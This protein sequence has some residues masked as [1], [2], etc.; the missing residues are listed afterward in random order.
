ME[1]AAFAGFI[2][3]F[4]TSNTKA[5]RSRVNLV[6][7]IGERTLG[8]DYGLRRVGLAVSVGVAPRPLQ[9]VEHR[10]DPRRAALDVARVANSNL[11]DAIVVGMPFLLVGAEGE[12]ALATRRFIEELVSSAP[13]AKIFTLNETFTSMDARTQLYDMG[14]TGKDVKTYIDSTSAVM[15]LQ[16]Y[17]SDNDDY[18]A[19]VIHTPQPAG[20]EE[21]RSGNERITFAEWRKQIMDRAAQGSQTGKQPKKK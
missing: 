9:R 20:E 6:A 12:Q 5:P 3:V 10:N 15:L 1:T 7:R 4:S 8:V 17:F 21:R 16:R 2:P 14:I 19:E 13:W 18:K 11:A